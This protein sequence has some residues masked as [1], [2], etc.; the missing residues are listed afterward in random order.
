[1]T[2]RMAHDLNNHPREDEHSGG[3]VR[4]LGAKGTAVNAEARLRARL[5][6]RLRAPLQARL[7]FP[8]GSAGLAGLCCSQAGFQMS[9]LCDIS[10]SVG[11]FL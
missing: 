2:E 4:M 8:L 5:Q 9:R 10:M 6:A 11:S 7:R 3:R 1:M